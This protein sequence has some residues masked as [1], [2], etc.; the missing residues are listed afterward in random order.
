MP[1]PASAPSLSNSNLPLMSGGFS[2][3]DI[4]NFVAQTMASDPQTILKQQQKMLQCLPPAQRKAYEAMF[5]EIEQA[6]KLRLVK[7]TNSFVKAKTIY[8]FYF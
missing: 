7:C 6:M 8:K 3:K 2:L 4:N 5:V 1:S